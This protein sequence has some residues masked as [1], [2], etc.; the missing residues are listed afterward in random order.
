VVAGRPSAVWR[1]EDGHF[2]ERTRYH[3]GRG[4][5]DGRVLVLGCAFGRYFCCG[6]AYIMSISRAPIRDERGL[7]PGAV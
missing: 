1:H 5:G 6:G 2:R 4:L 3:A 7:L